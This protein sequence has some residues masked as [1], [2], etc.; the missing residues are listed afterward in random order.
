MESVLL[1]RDSAVVLVQL[2]SGYVQAVVAAPDREIAQLELERLRQ[3]LPTPEPV[4][5]HDVPVAFR[6][7][8]PNGPV[9]SLRAMCLNG[10]TSAR[11]TPP[12]PE[13]TSTRSCASSGRRTAAS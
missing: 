7:Y 1:D 4:P 12:P 2:G 10:T 9:P 11:T 8:S 6:T 3:L 13:H 5:R